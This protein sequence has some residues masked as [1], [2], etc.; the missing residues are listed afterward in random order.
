MLH[1][2]MCCSCLVRGNQEKCFISWN[3]YTF[4]SSL[5]IFLFPTHLKI[6][7]NSTLPFSL[8]FYL[9]QVELSKHKLILADDTAECLW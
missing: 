3:W 9:L 7:N 8:I 2:V 5:S 4:S 6:I 1:D